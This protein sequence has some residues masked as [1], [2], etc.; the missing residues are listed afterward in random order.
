MLHE[1]RE[2]A[3]EDLCRVSRGH[4][5]AQQRLGTAELLVRGARE[6]DLKAVT[7]AASGES[8]AWGVL[9]APASTPASLAHL[10]LSPV[11]DVSSIDPNGGDGRAAGAGVAARRR[12]TVC[13]SGFGASAATSASTSRFGFCRADSRMV[14]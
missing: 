10:E 14:R 1:Q 9:A 11:A 3:I 7:S 13:A 8:R 4:H 12:T 5:V 2:C 6:R